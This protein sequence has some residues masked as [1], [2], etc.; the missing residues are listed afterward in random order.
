MLAVSGTTEEPISRRLISLRVPRP[1]LAAVEEAADASGR[2][3]T[4]V[5]VDALESAYPPVAAATE[6]FY[7]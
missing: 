3:R 6:E 1:L 7:A 2:N 4:E 5:I